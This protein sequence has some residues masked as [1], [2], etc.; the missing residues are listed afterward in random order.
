MDLLNSDNAAYIQSITKDDALPDSFDELAVAGAAIVEG[1][2]AVLFWRA[3]GA[4]R[5]DGTG[6][7]EVWWALT[8]NVVVWLGFIA[9]TEL[10]VAYTSESPFREL[11]LIGL[12]MAVVVAVVPDDLDR[13]D[14]RRA[15]RTDDRSAGR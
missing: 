6:V 2:G 1:I 10:F 5:G 8:W 11:L 13:T 14:D 7:R 15:G 4:M 12:A 9:G 3:L